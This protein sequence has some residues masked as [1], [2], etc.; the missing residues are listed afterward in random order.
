MLCAQSEG[1]STDLLAEARCEGVGLGGLRLVFGGLR[2]VGL[3][4]LPRHEPDLQLHLEFNILSMLHEVRLGYCRATL[5]QPLLHSLSG[6]YCI[7]VMVVLSG[8][9][10]EVTMRR[11]YA[12]LTDGG[13]Q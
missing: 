13:V 12:Q 11:R 3:R 5:L 10:A 4:L 9:S 8:E 6:T 2:L 7:S 1:T